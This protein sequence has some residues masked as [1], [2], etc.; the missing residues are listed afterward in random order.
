MNKRLPPW[1]NIPKYVDVGFSFCLVTLLKLN[2]DQ[3][4][5][6]IEK[7]FSV[8]DKIL[9]VFQH[10]FLRS[11]ENVDLHNL[12]EMFGKMFIFLIFQHCVVRSCC[13][14]VLYNGIKIIG[15]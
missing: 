13:N 5:Q 8:R 7:I 9:P 12:S 4:S 6:G 1:H 2:L 3:I 15:R 10:G 14:L 11:E